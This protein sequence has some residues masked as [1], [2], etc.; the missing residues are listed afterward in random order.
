M[1]KTKSVEEIVK[2][3]KK[4]IV[5]LLKDS[6]GVFIEPSSENS[7]ISLI[8][9]EKY[10]KQLI[11]EVKTEI[12]ERG[13]SIDK[14]FKGIKG[15]RLTISLAPSGSKY[16]VVRGVREEDIKEFC[17]LSLDPSKVESYYKLNKKLPNGIEY[18]ERKE[19]LR[20][21]TK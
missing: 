4:R 20:F 18:N 16:K 14:N 1:S 9:L 8:E 13:K 7:I 15:E 11:D 19:S 17:K 3:D 10:L 6:K 2:V 5:S 21:Y 12:I